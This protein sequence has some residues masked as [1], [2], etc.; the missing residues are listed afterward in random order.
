MKQK[1]IIKKDDTQNT[2]VIKEY[3]ELDKEIT[4]FM[5]EQEYDREDIIRGIAGGSDELVKAIRNHDFYPPQ[6]IADKIAEKI[7]E[8]YDADINE[9]VELLLNDVDFL[10]R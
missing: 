4:S 8:I 7:T 10:V 5:G 3:A 2:L 6:L 9:A 1:Y